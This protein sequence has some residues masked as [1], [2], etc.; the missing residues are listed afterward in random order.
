MIAKFLSKTSL[1]LLIGMSCAQATT[2]DYT[3]TQLSGTRWRYDYTVHNDT[4]GSPL[5]DFT[6]YFNENLFTNLINESTQASWDLLLIQPDK[7]IPAAGFFD[8][9]APGSG[10]AFGASADGFSVSF[11]YLGTGMP[12]RQSFSIY[13]TAT[14][15]EIEKGMTG[16]AAVPLPGTLSLLAIGLAAGAVQ[17][18][19]STVQ[20]G[21]A[22]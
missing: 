9:L 19:R 16:S 14:W 7:N 1:V 12:G 15:G 13:E 4:L 20:R 10:L 18:R 8:G 21:G 6:I 5:Q 2:I 11:D 22:Q 3:A 17:R